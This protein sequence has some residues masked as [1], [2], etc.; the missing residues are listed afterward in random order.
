MTIFFQSKESFNIKTLGA[1]FLLC[2]GISL[3]LYSPS[4][5]PHFV[6]DD[7]PLLVEN[8][9]HH[10]LKNISSFFAFN[11]QSFCNQRPLRFLSFAIDYHF[12][13]QSAFAFRI[14]NTF[15]HALVCFLA[16]VLIM[17][18]SKTRILAISAI[19][20]FL[21]H[22]LGT[23]AVA[24]ISGRRDLLMAIFSLATLLTLIPSDQ[25]NASR[26]KYALALLF[27]V[28]AYLSHESAIVLPFVWILIELAQRQQATKNFKAAL[29]SIFSDGR[30]KVFTFF[31]VITFALMLW[32]LSL[33]NTSTRTELWGS[34]ILGHIATLFRLHLR[35]LEVI[36][37]PKTLIAD[38]SPNA[39]ALSL[40]LLHPI[41]GLF[42]IIVL[43]AV[44]ALSIWQSFKRPMIAILPLI[45]FG[46]LVPTSQI[47]I[48]HELGAEHR[49][50]LP[51][52]ALY[53]FISILLFKILYHKRPVVFFAIVTLI[54]TL[55]GT[56]T[57]YRAKVWHSPMRLWSQTIKDVP[58]CARALSNLGALY[59]GKTQLKKAED[60][61]ERAL[62]ENPKLCDTQRNLAQVYI[63]QKKTKEGYALLKK[64]VAC[65]TTPKRLLNAAR[66]AL[67][68]KHD[69]DVIEFASKALSF[70]S[71]TEAFYLRG[72]AAMRLDKYSS[73]IVDFRRVIE[74]TNKNE[75]TLKAQIFLAEIYLR[76]CQTDKAIQD[77]KKAQMLLHALKKLKSQKK[78]YHYIE[79]L[80]ARESHARCSF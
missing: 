71:D 36:F 63:D 31:F 64:S 29:C 35:Y 76:Q 6:Y 62:K 45:Y 44:I 37:F 9:C 72:R 56:R 18:I 60:L 73:A 32:S 53:L 51:A 16:L 52:L 50:Y 40:S 38:Y 80:S 41:S 54:V 59:A 74:T 39:F 26:G 57:F 8:N 28:A 48:H 19:L 78:Y 17:R 55:L 12:F 23:E 2:W 34:G 69:K 25:K 7:I 27:F 49:L 33:R 79:K 1:F 3:A 43:I 20:I 67:R 66:I 10:S 61:L 21:V 14:I 15:Y 11:Q 24:Y 5:S 77:L 65:K 46:F 75:I 42:S 58:H 4:F 47:A 13:G 22:P 70:R 68:L 30:W